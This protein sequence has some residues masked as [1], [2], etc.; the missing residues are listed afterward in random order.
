MFS[1]PLSSETDHNM[2]FMHIRET[3]QTNYLG[4]QSIWNLI[5]I[6]NRFI[7]LENS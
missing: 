5:L 4:C 3:H 6:S 1:L 7:C 2:S